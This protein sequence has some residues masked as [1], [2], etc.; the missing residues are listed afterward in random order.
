MSGERH[1]AYGLG[2]SALESAGEASERSRLRPGAAPV[3]PV[4]RVLAGGLGVEVLV[5]GWLELAAQWEAE[6][7]G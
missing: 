5:V 6:R 7:S 4:G 1:W 3:A 2:E